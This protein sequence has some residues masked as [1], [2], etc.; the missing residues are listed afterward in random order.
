MFATVAQNGV[1]NRI[2]IVMKQ[3]SSHL[4]KKKTG[5]KCATVSR[6]IY[7]C[8]WKI[9][10]AEFLL[11]FL[12]FYLSLVFNNRTQILLLQGITL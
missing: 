10:F 11:H 6:L 2:K 3:D 4:F 12:K 1:E 8:D 5:R 7:K 9:I